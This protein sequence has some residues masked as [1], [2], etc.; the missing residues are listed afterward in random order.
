MFLREQVLELTLVQ[1]ILALVFL[2]SLLVSMGLFVY[3]SYCA[4]QILTEGEEI[5]DRQVKL[6]RWDLRFREFLVSLTT[7]YCVNPL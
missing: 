7:L 1:L 3:W 4:V 6:M 5:T 2:A